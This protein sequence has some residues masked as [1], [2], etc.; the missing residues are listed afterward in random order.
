MQL[1]K[2]FFVP[3]TK[4]FI[5]FSFLM[6]VYCLWANIFYV[7]V[8]FCLFVGLEMVSLWGLAHLKSS[9]LTRMT[10]NTKMSS[11]L[12]LECCLDRIV[13][14]CPDLVWVLTTQGPNFYTPPWLMT[15]YMNTYNYLKTKIMIVLLKRSLT[16]RFFILLANKDRLQRGKP[17]LKNA[18]GGGKKK[19]CTMS[20]KS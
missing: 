3:N 4:L 20:P 7:F 6:C 10:L 15:G 9:V 2:Y 11:F 18:K 14:P 13:Q 8:L 1:Y 16:L 12:S 19:P 5:S 17:C